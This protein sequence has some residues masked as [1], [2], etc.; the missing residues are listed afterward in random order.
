MSHATI[1]STGQLALPPEL[2]D[3]LGLK[4]GMKIDFHQSEDGQFVMTINEPDVSAL[5]GILKSDQ[6]LTI[7]QMH[8]IIT[9]SAAGEFDRE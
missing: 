6:N 3:E 7:E 4:P 8:Q 9:A 2:R 1:T 5:F